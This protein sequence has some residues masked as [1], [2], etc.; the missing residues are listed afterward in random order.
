[1]SSGASSCSRRAGRRP[2]GTLGL[3]ELGWGMR[4]RDTQGMDPG[5]ERESGTRGSGSW[6]WGGTCPPGAGRPQLHGDQCADPCSPRMCTTRA[7]LLSDGDFSAPGPLRAGSCHREVS[8]P[9]PPGRGHSGRPPGG[10]GAPRWCSCR[11]QRTHACSPD[12]TPGDTPVEALTP[13]RSL[14]GLPKPGWSQSSPCPE[15]PGVVEGRPSGEGLA[16]LA[17]GS[18][19]GSASLTLGAFI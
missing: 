17:L 1:M 4:F 2:L 10:P 15:S 5:S 16:L 9:V 3:A 8:A 13:A 6:A 12:T 14:P 11:A 18:R 19:P 7:P